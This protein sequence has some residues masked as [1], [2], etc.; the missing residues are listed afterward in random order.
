MFSFSVSHSKKM[1]FLFL[2]IL[3]IFSGGCDSVNDRYQEHKKKH[4]PVVAAFKA[5]RSEPVSEERSL[6]KKSVPTKTYVGALKGKFSV[7]AQGASNYQIPIAVPPGIKNLQAELIVAYASE[8]ANSTLGLGWSVSGLSSI[9]RC[10]AIVPTDGFKGGVNFDNNDR[11]C[12]NGERLILTSA[13][14]VYGADQS[15]YVLERS[16]WTQVTANGVC[17][18]GP[19]YFKLLTKKGLV[20]YFGGHDL[21]PS[22]SRISA[23]AQASVR[24]WA[25]SKTVDLQ[26]NAITYLYSSDQGAYVPDQIE[27]TAN[28]KAGFKSNRSV[29]FVYD[30]NRSDPIVKYVGGFLVQQNKLL[31]NIETKVNGKVVLDYQF[32]YLPSVMP[33]TI[34]Q[35][36]KCDALGVC[37]T[38]SVFENMPEPSQFFSQMTE[39]ETLGGGLGPIPMDVDGNGL[40]DLVN[41]V[42]SGLQTQ[43]TILLSDGNDF[44]AQSPQLLGEAYEPGSLLS[45]D[46]NGDGSMDLMTKY[47]NGTGTSD[48]FTV[49]L[50]N[51]NA[52]VKQATT[53]EISAGGKHFLLDVN[54]DGLVDIV[55]QDSSYSLQL[56]IYLSNGSGFTL[57]PNCCSP[58]L[59]SVAD[60]VASDVSGDGLT[61]LVHIAKTAAGVDITVLLSQESSVTSGAPALSFVAQATQSFSIAG[62]GVWMPSDLNGD[63]N[64]DMVYSAPD[65]LNFEIFTLLSNARG[66]ETPGSKIF[67][68]VPA[69]GD[70]FVVDIDTDGFT[71]LMYVDKSGLNLELT[72]FHSNGVVLSDCTLQVCAELDKLTIPS[73]NS[74]IPLDYNGDSKTDFVSFI[75]G[76]LYQQFV[77]NKVLTTPHVNALSLVTNGLGA[78]VAVSYLPLTNESV[79]D[80]TPITQSSNTL[81]GVQGFYNRL[82]NATYSTT[83]FSQTTPGSR[84]SDIN[85][86]FPKYVVAGTGYSNGHGLNDAFSYFYQGAKQAPGT[87]GFLGFQARTKSIKSSGTMYVQQ[88]LQQHPYTGEVMQTAL[89]CDSKNPVDPK[90][91]IPGNPIL[92]QTQFNYLCEASGVCDASSAKIYQPFSNAYSLNRSVKTDTHYDYGAFSHAIN[93]AYGYDQFS[94]R[95]LVSYLGY[96]DAK[97]QDISVNDNIYTHNSYYSDVSNHLFAYKTLS[98]LSADLAGKQVLKQSQSFY[99]LPA[100]AA[101][102]KCHASQIYSGSMNLICSHQWVNTD[103]TWLSTQYSYDDYGNEISKQAPGE[104]EFLT[105]YETEFNT[106]PLENISPANEQGLAL[107]S[108]TYYDAGFGALILKEDANDNPSIT[109]LDGLGNKVAEQGPIPSNVNGVVPDVNCLPAVVSKNSVVTLTKYQNQHDAVSGE[110]Y[111]HIQRRQTW[112]IPKTGSAQFQWAWSKKY[113]DG[114]QRIYKTITQGQK[115]DGNILTCRNFNFNQQSTMQSFPDY[116]QSDNANCDS[117][118]TLAWM[119]KSYDAYGRLVKTTSPSTTKSGSRQISETSYLGET[120]TSTQNVGSPEQFE[121]ILNYQYINRLQKVVTMLVPSELRQLPAASKTP[122][123][124]NLSLIADGYALL[125]QSP[126]KICQ[127]VPLPGG[128]SATT[129]FT[130][131]RLAR[132]LVVREPLTQSNPQGVCN[133]NLLDSLDRTVWSYEPSRNKTNYTYG[134]N[135]KRL[136]K[137]DA[138]NQTSHYAYDQLGR[139]VSEKLSDKNVYEFSYDSKASLNGLGKMT[140]VNIFKNSPTPFAQYHYQYSHYNRK[141]GLSFQIEGDSDVFE[142]STVFDP[143]GRKTQ[144]T[145]PDKT[146]LSRDYVLHNLEGISLTHFG[147]LIAYDGYTP[148]DVPQKAIYKNGVKSLYDYSLIGDLNSYEITDSAGTELINNT[149]ERN[150]AG[151]IHTIDDQL[152]KPAGAP[153]YT[154]NF[155][156]IN[157]RLTKASAKASY[158]DFEYQYDAGGNMIAKNTATFSYTGHQVKTGKEKGKTFLT[159][160]YDLNGNLI[161][162]TLSGETVS[163]QY[164][165]KDRM[166]AYKNA[167]GKSAKIDYGYTTQ[168]IKKELSDGT[169]SIYL[170]STFEKQTLPNG[171]VLTIKNIPG[172]HGRVATVTGF[173]EKGVPKTEH[174]EFLHQNRLNSTILSTSDTGKQKIKLFYQPYGQLWKAPSVLPNATFGGKS[175]DPDSGLYYFNARYYDPR[176][177]FTSA[178]NQLGGRPLTPNSFNRYAYVLNNPV[179]F[180]DSSGH[181][182]CAGLGRK[183]VIGSALA[184]T[185]VSGGLGIS[186][187]YENDDDK[188]TSQERALEIFGALGTIGTGAIA[189]ACDLRNPATVAPETE[190]RRIPTRTQSEPNLR[191]C[192]GPQSFIAGTQVSTLD[193]T[194]AVHEFETGNALWSYNF[195][196]QEK[197]GKEILETYNRISTSKVTLSFKDLAINTTPEHRFWL[198]NEGWRE[199]GQLKAGDVLVN[200]D[201][202]AV[203]VLGVKTEKGKFHVFNFK[204]KDNASYY[205]SPLALLTHNQ[206][207]EGE[208]EQSSQESSKAQD[209]EDEESEGESEEVEGTEGAEEGAEAGGEAGAEAGAEVGAEIGAEAGADVAVEVAEALLLLLL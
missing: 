135:N 30:S 15:S 111:Q 16:P 51:K 108:K 2:C 74:L 20:K 150:D 153:D 176:G 5:L 9:D 12:L 113:I 115:K 194:K 124:E 140:G 119:K 99:D 168:R 209:S 187:A 198:K 171:T 81:V 19:C 165:P 192:P 107:H 75:P 37:M 32:Q 66:F 44:Q 130:Y 195:D 125:N 83:N 159:A 134:A 173:Q 200:A 204:V 164:D 59:S 21:S 67:Q 170:G 182:A 138:L 206:G 167:K 196:K 131:D 123:K 154:Q 62:G 11:F 49:Y 207:C 18:S 175:W 163:Y 147:T 166:V 133:I 50:S 155:D 52:F 3:V 100:S 197:E 190:L 184:V 45:L 22:T 6:K 48:V 137:T 82:S 112:G 172:K 136:Q 84:L 156:Y 118:S 188:K 141:S 93:E 23:L 14:K 68:K 117:L 53:T 43:V 145:F 122:S 120:S 64:A 77:L 203:P 157:H 34:S 162:K 127:L 46:V 10:G 92:K 146:V 169:V 161:S 152:N 35:I 87:Y 65:G 114:Y 128:L 86:V 181:F 54:G 129:T 103:K 180:K 90:C 41:A 110:N 178:D 139:K 95:T 60:M 199:A 143:Q 73:G 109:C 55:H 88:F 96:V 149:Y 104:G 28:E 177:H 70:L 201:D 4:S 183:L 105:T 29:S 17:G 85:V 58:A 80:K 39:N 42:A 1:K 8:T 79:Y 186:I 33:S 13:T 91:N 72:V 142:S 148:F 26:K 31:T 76:G 121:K 38:P 151:Y 191:V 185:A 132:P 27:Y 40:T 144:I 98:V 71:D 25:L 97:G 89:H 208:E 193:G 158:G 47:L 7:S 179:N 116:I 202:Q 69:K 94:N 189:A 63:G 205:V 106:Y 174:I 57:S 160:S 61:D 126:S 56:S 78:T 24:V 102:A 101:L 36:T